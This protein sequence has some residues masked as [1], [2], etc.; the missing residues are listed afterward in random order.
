MSVFGGGYK[1]DY[2][3]RDKERGGSDGKAVSVFKW[4]MRTLTY[5]LE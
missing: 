3:G 4:S 5:V 2:G 1:K